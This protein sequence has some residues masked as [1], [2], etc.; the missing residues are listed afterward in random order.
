MPHRAIR[1]DP[2]GEPRNPLAI[3][4]LC[5]CLLSGLLM[6]GGVTT[7]K[8][9]EAAL[10]AVVARVWG[11][12]LSFGSASTLVGMYWQGSIQAGLLAKRVGMF[13][14]TVASLIYAIIIIVAFGLAG[15]LSSG[16]ILGFS[17][18][19]AVQYRR[20]N[21]RVTAII[22]TSKADGDG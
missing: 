1:P 7:A 11:T 20:L 13:S 16:I 8:S 17:F 18:A 22:L 5:L 2:L 10:P 9:V 3:F 21:R 15:L 4:L 12:M 6:L 19:C 14:L